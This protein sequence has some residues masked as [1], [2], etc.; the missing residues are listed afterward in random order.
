MPKIVFVSPNGDEQEVHVTIGT[1]IMQAA[2]DNG[3]DAIVAE[4]GGACSCATCHVYI[5]ETWLPKLVP[6]SDIESDMIECVI[7]PEPNSRLSCQIAIEDS[8]DGIV[9]RLPASQF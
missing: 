7:D 4:C 8:L 3:I 5:D 1:S 6:R 2:V 9:V